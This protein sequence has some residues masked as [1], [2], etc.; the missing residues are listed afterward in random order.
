MSLCARGKAAAIA[1]FK[2]Y[3]SAYANGHAVKVCLGK[4]ADLSGKRV[5][6][7]KYVKHYQAMKSSGRSWS[8]SSRRSKSRS[9]K[10]RHLK[11]GSSN[12]RRWFDE[13][14]INVC[15][16]KYDSS[17]H[18]VKAVPCGRSKARKSK[19]PY[20]RPLRKMSKDTP[21]TVG[22]LSKRKR[23]EMCARKRRSPE[24]IIRLR[25]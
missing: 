5:A 8:K 3:P 13:E 15:E 16:S 20:C 11:G 4:I 7:S 18:L 23:A 6:D 14:W 12:L 25:D 24:K 17:G 22:S 2:V 19:Y 21:R 1:R 9:Q 10:K